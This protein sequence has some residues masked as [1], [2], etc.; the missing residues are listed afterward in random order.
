MIAF[1]ICYK[2]S[3]MELTSKFVN[4]IIYKTILTLQGYIM[5]QFIKYCP[6]CF[7]T[8]TKGWAPMFLFM[9][10][11]C[12]FFTFKILW[13]CIQKEKKVDFFFSTTKWTWTSE[14]GPKGIEGWF[15]FANLNLK[16]FVIV[17]KM[18]WWWISILPYNPPKP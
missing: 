13:L 9:A 12:H 1:K 8:V 3:L 16:G 4:N 11:Y 17:I 5:W 18:W 15:W 10:N 6:H 7:K 2:T 14:D